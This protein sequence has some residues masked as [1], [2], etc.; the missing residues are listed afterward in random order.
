[1]GVLLST[2]PYAHRHSFLALWQPLC[3]DMISLGNYAISERP[4]LY[5]NIPARFIKFFPIIKLTTFLFSSTCLD[6]SFPYVHAFFSGVSPSLYRASHVCLFLYVFFLSLFFVY[7]FPGWFSTYLVP[8]VKRKLG[9][10]WSS[11]FVFIHMRYER[12]LIYYY[13]NECFIYRE[14]KVTI[15]ERMHPL[16]NQ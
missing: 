15:H 4:S 13:N 7:L 2:Q 3:Q 5:H 12:Y 14:H 9:S 16:N 8:S 10:S 6:C 1:M 11:M